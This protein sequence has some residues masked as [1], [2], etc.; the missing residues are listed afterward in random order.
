MEII[1][2]GIFIVDDDDDDDGY[3]GYDEGYDDDDN[4]IYRAAQ[5][6]LQWKL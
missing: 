3:D 4:K 1:R 6:R 5:W 2:I